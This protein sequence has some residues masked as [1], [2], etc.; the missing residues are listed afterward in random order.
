VT[1]P[2]PWHDFSS[3]PRRPESAPLRAADRDRAVVLAALGDAYADGRLTKEEYDE[4]ADATAATKTLGELTPLISDLVPHN[5][6]AMGRRPA[7]SEELH[8]R[9]VQRWESQRRQALI[10]FLV[11]TIICWTIWLLTS[12]GGD[13]SFPWP[14]FVM[15][16]TGVN[17]LQVQLRRQDLVAE[18]QRKL[19]KKQRK[20]LEARRPRPD[21]R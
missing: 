3:D 17:L 13:W 20:A 15:L 2:V 7:S 21:T 12:M 9:A 14:A 19:E 1:T 16:G 18:E 10:G 4:R 5:P 11:P 6:L 8:R